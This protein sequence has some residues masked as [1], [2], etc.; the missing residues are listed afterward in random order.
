MD[1]I[2]KWTIKKALYPTEEEMCFLTREEMV[3]NGVEDPDELEIFYTAIEIKEDGTLNT[4]MQLPKRRVKVDSTTWFERDGV[5]FYLL[6]GEEDQLALT[7]DGL[8]RFS[9]GMMLMERQ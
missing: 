6:D 4:Y 8:L 5:Y 1:L 9:M 7:E 2:G 3:A